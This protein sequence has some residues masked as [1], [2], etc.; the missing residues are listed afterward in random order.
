MLLSNR[1]DVE[2]QSKEALSKLNKE[3][4]KYIENLKKEKENMADKVIK[5][6]DELQRAKEKTDIEKSGRLVAEDKVALY[7]KRDVLNE[8]LRALEADFVPME[9]EREMSFSNRGSKLLMIIG[10]FFYWGSCHCYC[11][12]NSFGEVWDN[13]SRCSAV[14]N[15]DFLL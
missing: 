3:Q 14:R 10:V 11:V 1:L 12:C 2:V 8:E 15:W 7:K 6:K 5:A 4:E 9:A 13:S